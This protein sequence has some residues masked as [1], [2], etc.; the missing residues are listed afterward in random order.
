MSRFRY[1]RSI[2]VPYDRQG[3]IYF[4]S[5]RYRELPAQDRKRIR[6][7]CRKA[8]GDYSQ[9]LLEFVTTSQGAS[10]V[11]EKHFLSE[12]TLER[13]VRKYYIQFAQIL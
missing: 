4:L 7:L 10:A 13:I 1:K 5:I 12:S 11:C 6:E 9:A 8:G 2:P 3:F